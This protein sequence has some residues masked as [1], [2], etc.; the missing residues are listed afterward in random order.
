MKTTKLHYLTMLSAALA[1]LS[2][3]EKIDYGKNFNGHGPMLEKQYHVDGFKNIEM[4]IDADVYLTQGN[5]QPIIIKGQGNILSNLSVI[6]EHET[7]K[8][9]YLETVGNHE[10][11]EVH[12][13]LPLLNQLS[14][15]RSAH[16]QS[17]NEFTTDCLIVQVYGS[18]KINMGISHAKY[19][20]SQVTGSGQINLRGNADKLDIVITGSGSVLSAGLITDQSSVQLTGNGSCEVYSGEELTVHING[21]G[22][23][24]YAGSPATLHSNLSGSGELRKID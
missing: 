6:T 23:V 9:N 17:L 7:L 14:T 4:D 16:I 11:L 12:I 18:G 22:K 10:R 8:F 24:Y 2:A 5:I 20:R 1:I 15:I 21:N 19:I 3:C 13:S